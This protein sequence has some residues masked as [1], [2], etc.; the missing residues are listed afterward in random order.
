MRVNYEGVEIGIIGAG[1]ITPDPDWT[2]APHKHEHYE[3]HFITEGIGRNLLEGGEIEL[4]PGM[5]YLAPP[6]EIHAQ[7]SDK[8]SPL[9]LYFVVF[10]LQLPEGWEPLPRIYAPYSFSSGDLLSIFE[11]MNGIGDAGMGSRLL[12]HMRLIEMIW[13]VLES[14][15]S[16]ASSLPSAQPLNGHGQPSPVLQNA[17]LYIQQHFYRNPTVAEIAV[18]CFVS[19]R[20]L[21]RMFLR[22]MQMTVNQYVQHER[23]FYASTELKHSNASLQDIAERLQFSSVQYFAQWFKGLSSA[24][25]TEFRK[26]HFGS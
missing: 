12:G 20:H 4:Y 15:L 5:V 14:R 22:Q 2:I 13:K 23:L 9:G 1:R 19:E 10:D 8:S 26:K 6:H 17:V 25:P 3:I 24:T 21:S 11:S 18:A 7:F 16:N